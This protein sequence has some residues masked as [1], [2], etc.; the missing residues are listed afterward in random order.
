MELF[1]IFCLVVFGVFVFLAFF[2][3]FSDIFFGY[4]LAFCLCCKVSWCFSVFRPGMVGC[5][6]LVEW[7]FERFLVGVACC[8]YRV[9]VEF[10]GVF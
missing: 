7:F 9:F 6:W 4:F 3:V 10:Y 1:S 8:F 2:G 5:F